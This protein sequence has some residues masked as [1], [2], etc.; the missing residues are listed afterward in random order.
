M[1]RYAVTVKK[2][3]TSET[4]GHLPRK[5]SQRCSIFLQSGGNITAMVTGG[6]RYF[7]LVQDGLEIP[8]TLKFCGN[9][10]Q[11]LKLKKL[12]K[13]RKHL[14]QLLSYSFINRHN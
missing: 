13:Q 8:C 10:Q 4:V 14:Q 11:I 7:N 12:R 5:V 3:V 9:A 6:R 1:D 2:P